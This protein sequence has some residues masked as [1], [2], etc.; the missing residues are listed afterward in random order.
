MVY[1]CFKK[2]PVHLAVGISSL[3]LK[4]PV[5]QFH[6][7]I[8]D[9]KEACCFKVNGFHVGLIYLHWHRSCVCGL[10]NRRAA[11]PTL[12]KLYREYVLSPMIESSADFNWRRPLQQ[13]FYPR[14][15][16]ES[17]LADVVQIVIRHL[18]ERVTIADIPNPPHERYR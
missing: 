4:M 5:N 13:E 8:S 17:S 9:K 2:C 10:P 1:L 11:N 14:I 15:R 6:A 12:V 3:L 16:H 7:F 18:R